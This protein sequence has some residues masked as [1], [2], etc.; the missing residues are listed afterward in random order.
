M[1]SNPKIIDF[2]PTFD[3]NLQVCKYGLSADCLKIADSSC[4]HGRACK[5]C[6][7]ERSKAKYL[8]HRDELV[9]KQR[10]Y[11]HRI[12]GQKKVL[13]TKQAIADYLIRFNE[14]IAKL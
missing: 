8:D 10:V 13:K 6:N 12:R 4:F 11:N 7:K 3:R 5:N 2:S 9:L 1:N 14:T